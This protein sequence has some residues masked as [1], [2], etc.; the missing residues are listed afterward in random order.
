MPL[1]SGP[2]LV[3]FGMRRCCLLAVPSGGMWSERLRL[4]GTQPLLGGTITWWDLCWFRVRNIV[5]AIL[6]VRGVG[7]ADSR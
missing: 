7:E 6:G 1:D 2:G 3:A 4:S 5:L